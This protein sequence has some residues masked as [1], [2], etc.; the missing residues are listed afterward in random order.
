MTPSSSEL[1][2]V[3]LAFGKPAW[4]SSWRAA[5]ASWAMSPESIRIPTGW[6]PAAYS[7]LKTVMA[8]GIPDFK[9]S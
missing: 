2:A 8:L 9:T 6:W 7:S 4:S 3:I 5:V 1:E